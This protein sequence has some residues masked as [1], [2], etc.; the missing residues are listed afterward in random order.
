MTREEICALTKIDPWFLRQLEKMLE[1]ESRVT[2]SV[3]AQD[4]RRNCCAKPSARAPATKRLAQAVE[5]KSAAVRK[6]GRTGRRARLQ[7]RGYLRGRI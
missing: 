3:T 7:A 5:V 6:R 2:A 4:L 1:I